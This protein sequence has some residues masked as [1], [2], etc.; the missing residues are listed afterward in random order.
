M[1][2]L[3]LGHV[4]R[5]LALV[6][7]LSESPRR[8]TAELAE[9]LDVSVRTVQRDLERLEAAGLDPR[10]PES[11]ERLPGIEFTA[12]EARALLLVAGRTERDR[13]LPGLPGLSQAAKKLAESLPPSSV[14]AVTPGGGISVE[15]PAPSQPAR[16]GAFFPIFE[17]AL[18]DRREVRASYDSVYEGQQL[19]LTLRPYHLM[20]HS[21]A[22]YVIAWSSL[23]DA[24]RTFH[25]GRVLTVWPAESTYEIPADFSPESHLGN[26][27]RLIPGGPDLEVGV[28]FSPQ[29]ARSVADVLWHKTQRLAWHDDG[30]LLFEATVS[31]LGEIVSWLLG[32]GEQAEVL[33]P[34]ELRTK[35]RDAA[36]AMS[37]IYR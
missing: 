14:E 15:W 34:P 37:R 17:A 11:P 4:A 21:R 33:S 18:R 28:R 36:F 29:V 9:L 19:D 35:M 22:W 27:W 10:T 12:S 25:L 31:G 2:E 30:S 13:P 24:V 32:Y 23:H 3:S 1:L 5:L 16:A 8:T 20:F 26:A 7:A 6:E